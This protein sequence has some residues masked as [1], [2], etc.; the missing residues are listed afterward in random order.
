[1]AWTERRIHRIFEL[2]VLLKGAHAIVECLAGVALALLS[3]QTIL[4]W[5]TWLTQHE[6]TDDPSDL[7]ANLLLDMAQGFSVSAKAFYVFYLLSHGI[8]K[9]FLVA[10]LLRNKSWAYP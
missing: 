6:L 4:G 9:L 1:M 10:G 2:S 8:V 5:V 3:T 7:V